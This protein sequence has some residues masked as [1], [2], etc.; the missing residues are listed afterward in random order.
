[1][2]VLACRMGWLAGF[3]VGLLLWPL[4]AAAQEFD[5]KAPPGAR[6][7]A[8]P[9][10]MRDL[11]ERILPVYE[12]KDTDRYLTNLA[13]LQLVA[14][15]YPAADDTRRKLRDR[16]GAQAMPGPVE[17]ELLYDIYAQ[18]RALEARE[19][20]AFDQAF[21]R[22]F[23]ELVPTL[24]DREA[25]ALTAWIE[26]PAARF[27]EALQRELDRLRGQERIALQ[28][29]VDLVWTYL[30]FD[31]HRSFRPIV[32][33]L[34]AEDAQR[35]Y[36]SE[37]ELRLR[38][39]GGLQISAQIVRPRNQARP[40]PTLLAVTLDPAEG[41]ARGAAAHGYVGVVAY[42]RA[43][44]GARWQQ[45]EPFRR[46]GADARAVVR[47][48]TQQPWSDG[49]VGLYGEGYS[50]FAAWAALKQPLAAIK[51]IATASP[52]APGIDFPAPGRIFHNDAYRWAQANAPT[53]GAR[54]GRRAVA[55]AALD[56]AWYRSG[57]AYRELDRRFAT[58]NHVFRTWLSHPSFDRYWQKTQ[59]FD[60]E[61]ARI[62]I[63]V[64]TIAGAYAGD[65]GALHYFHEHL[66]HRPDADHSLLI[67]P[68][69]ASALREGPAPVLRGYPVDAAAL[70]D[71]RALRFAWFDHVL[72]DGPKP[73]LL[74]DRVNVQMS[75]ANDWRHAPT[76][77]TLSTGALRLYLD[78]AAKGTAHRLLAAPTKARR[79]V[80]QTV[81]FRSRKNTIAP[82]A[83]DLIV[84]DPASADS[85]MFV[86]EPLPEALEFSGR[87]GGLLDLQPN[88]QD[89]DLNLRLYERLPDGRHLELF[90]PYE[91]RASYAADPAHR[92]LLQAGVRQ[93][94]A[95]SVERVGSRRLGAGSRVV[96]VIGVNRR[97]DR[98]INYGTGQEVGLESIADAQ[99]PL[100][101]RW[102]NGSYIELPV[103]K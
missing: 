30:A 28:A 23:R 14:G 98:Q 38:L 22:S 97:P 1:M 2:I 78:P 40:L 63:P 39:P 49:R 81:D 12:D 18:A 48:I 7:A 74:R 94:L 95:F 83:V 24:A 47:W 51:A 66:R 26:T 99:V 54:P 96:L 11:A 31:A 89:L 90:A 80:L 10:V 79:S 62:G 91:F 76:I 44:R 77:E 64:L 32:R 29:A 93:S 41:D 103:R 58:P 56:A 87:V 15:T 17:R 50:G 73:A 27:E 55:P 16:R 45:I 25:D 36:T 19:Q 34:E 84:R 69:G 61:F 5:F 35:R 42:S 82:Q 71:L 43:G 60:R 3:A 21:T 9:V 92:R 33:A 70:V 102:F 88:K 72:R 46:D 75:G 101:L 6:D 20:V 8:M 4:R 52:M 67:G 65:A 59:P 85:L 57:L 86:S 37:E 100:K 13:A 53:P 68:Y